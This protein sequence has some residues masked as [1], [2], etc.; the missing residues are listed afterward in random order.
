MVTPSVNEPRKLD[1]NALTL[2][3]KEDPFSPLVVVLS[4]NN[5]VHIDASEQQALPVEGIIPC[6][7]SLPRLLQEEDDPQKS[8]LFK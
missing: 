6:L 7:T 4:K 1:L 3:C 2:L 8:V 5:F